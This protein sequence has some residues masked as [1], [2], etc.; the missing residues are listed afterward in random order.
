VPDLAESTLE[1]F[2]A[3]VYGFDLTIDESLFDFVSITAPVAPPAPVQPVIPVAPASIPVASGT[4]LPRARDL[5]F[6][7]VTGK[8][9]LPGGDFVFTQD[10]EAI[11]QA[12]Q[13]RLQSVQ[14]ELFLDLGYGIPWFDRV[15][16]KSPNL[17]AV[18]AV[19]RKEIEGVPGVLAVTSL[20]SSY[21]R[22][23]RRFAITWTANTDLG[24]ISGQTTPALPGQ[25]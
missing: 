15:L 21:D 18:E 16:V 20:V 4:A 10:L 2:D 9:Y 22:A 7:F 3:S 14:G 12:V 25:G 17:R 19:F 24:E 5:G 1:F 8:F 6:D 13:I 23:T 11:K